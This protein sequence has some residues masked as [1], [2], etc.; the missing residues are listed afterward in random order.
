M[1]MIV[2]PCLFMMPACSMGKPEPGQQTNAQTNADTSGDTPVFGILNSKCREAIKDAQDF[3]NWEKSFDK[4]AKTACSMF[5]KY[6]SQA[7]GYEKLRFVTEPAGSY[8]FMIA[9]IEREITTVRAIDI[10]QGVIER[11]TEGALDKFAKDIHVLETTES[12][13]RLAKMFHC[14]HVGGP[15]SLVTEYEA[16]SWRAEQNEPKVTK[17]EDGSMT[18]VYDLIHTG[19]RVSVKQCTVNISTDYKVTLDCIEKEKKN[20]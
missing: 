8:Y 17:N 9:Y 14:F 2:I 18:L 10:N 16:E 20:R 1:P 13:R 3:D 7:G 4:G 15:M 6:L 19:R 5:D 12:A 11:D